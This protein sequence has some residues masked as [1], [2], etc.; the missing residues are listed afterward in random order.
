MKKKIVFIGRENLK[1]NASTIRALGMAEPLTALGYSITLLL[2]KDPDNIHLKKAN[3]HNGF[4]IRLSNR[5]IFEFFSKLLLLL[6]IR[7]DFV[8]CLN[9]GLNSTMVGLIYKVINP[10]VFLIW[11][12]DELISE[13]HSGRL[14]KTWLV[15]NE[16]MTAHFAD[17]ILTASTYLQQVLSGRYGIKTRYFPYAVNHDIFEKSKVKIQT[18]NKVKITYFGS[19]QTY[20]NFNV[21]LSCIK[22]CSEIEHNWEFVFMG[23]GAQRSNFDKFIHE[24]SLKNVRMLGFVDDDIAIKELLD[25]TVFLLPLEDNRINTL[26]CPNKLFW[27]MAA[28]KPI[29]TNKVGEVFRILGDRGFYYEF[30]SVNDLYNKI[31]LSLNSP[32]VNYNSA[33]FSWKERVAYY[34][35]NILAER[36]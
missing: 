28:G 6:K 35:S 10:G 8:H 13:L 11:D 24:N 18:G 1:K 23:D 17:S 14:R 2:P 4:D 5:G 36:Q 33:G 3:Q 30:A 22:K 31:T 26:R 29:V 20:F 32:S 9:A 34:E 21:I 15:F 27:Y 19:L 25:S 16:G 7:P 12:A